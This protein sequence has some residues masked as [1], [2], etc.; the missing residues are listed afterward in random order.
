MNS[1]YIK[2]AKYFVEEFVHS[3][4]QIHFGSSTRLG[5]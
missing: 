3:N 1:V 5:L 4:Q 2:I